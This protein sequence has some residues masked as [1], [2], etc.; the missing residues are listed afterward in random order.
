MRRS[1]G[2]ARAR[3]RV[4]Q[5]ELLHLRCAAAA[6][7]PLHRAH[8]PSCHNRRVWWWALDLNRCAEMFCRWLFVSVCELGSAQLVRQRHLTWMEATAIKQ[9]QNVSNK[10]H[11]WGM[12]ERTHKRRHTRTH[13]NTRAP[14]PARTHEH[15]QCDMHGVATY[16]SLFSPERLQG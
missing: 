2:G 4:A 14:T 15:M 7:R 6:T 1:N 13:T 8:A 11:A 10:G 9:G 3:G 16:Q 5:I 12:H